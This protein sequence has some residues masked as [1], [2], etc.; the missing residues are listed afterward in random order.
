MN[1]GAV[2]PYRYCTVMVKDVYGDEPVQIPE[3]YKFWTFSI[4][5]PGEYFLAVPSRTVQKQTIHDRPMPKIIL[6]KL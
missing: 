4:P 1:I 2:D 3:G 6:D 5:Q